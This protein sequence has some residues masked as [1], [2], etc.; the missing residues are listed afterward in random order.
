MYGLLADGV[1]LVHVAYVAFVILGQA[2]IV[3]AAPFRWQWARN[4]W[5]RFAHLTMIAVVA[6]EAIR[7]LRCPL[8]AWEEQLRTLAG[9]TVQAGDTFLGRLLHNLLFV[10]GMPEVFF[11]TLYL[12]MLAV[13]LQGLVMYPPRGFRLTGTRRSL[14]SAA[15]PQA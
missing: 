9:Q 1:V 6:Y 10:E 4:P 3:V 2:A 15:I 5:F 8:T 13:V 12:A 7:G 14:Q 11:T